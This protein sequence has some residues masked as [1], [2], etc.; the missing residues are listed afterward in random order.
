MRGSGKGRRKSPRSEG[1]LSLG[2]PR[3]PDPA[4]IA[5]AAC[6][7][8]PIEP[9]AQAGGPAPAPAPSPPKPAAA[10]PHGSAHE[11]A[12][13]ASSSPTEV[14]ALHT[15]AESQQSSSGAATPLTDAR[16]AVSSGED[17]RQRPTSPVPSLG[18]ISEG[19]GPELQQGAASPAA[20][21]AA[22]S[23]QQ[24][25]RQ[26]QQ[27]ARPAAPPSPSRAA[28]APA[29]SALLGSR[30]S[31][32]AA[33][34]DIPFLVQRLKQRPIT[35]QVAAWGWDAAARVAA[36]RRTL[37]AQLSSSLWPATEAC[38]CRMM[39]QVGGAGCM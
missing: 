25:Q 7:E 14:A 3:P 32:S 36:L 16:S 29:A 35:S 15:A 4:S 2:P 1:R 13:A 33:A 20:S 39:P 22:A 9:A 21:T 38:M 27:A 34:V 11:E 19:S 30:P 8:R 37:P 17:E 23:P 18:T 26:Q 5:H 12:Q 28:S 6:R 31:G 24:Q 10:L